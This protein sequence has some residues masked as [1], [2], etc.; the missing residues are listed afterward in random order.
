MF[1]IG[2]IPLLPA[3]VGGVAAA[4]LTYELGWGSLHDRIADLTDGGLPTHEIGVLLSNPT[5]PWIYGEATGAF[6]D[7]SAAEAQL[8]GPERHIDDSVDAFRHAYGSALLALRMMEH[9]G[10]N[11]ADA[12]QLTTDIGNAHEAD[13]TPE[14]A[15]AH[16]MDESNNESGLSLLG[17]GKNADG[18]WMTDDQLRD[19]ILQAMRS[20]GLVR[21]D[22]TRLVPTDGGK[23]F[24]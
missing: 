22:D 9:H 19:R 8:F 6:D 18:S 11:A 12:A 5:K 24:H 4:G 13:G 2:R 10:M 21:I 20:G 7:A 3:A 15:L 23:R 14:S 1:S 16:Q 17:D